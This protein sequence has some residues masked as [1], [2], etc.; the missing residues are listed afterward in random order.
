LEKIVG[1]YEMACYILG[2]DN[3]VRMTSRKA[4]VKKNAIH[5]SIPSS[6]SLLKTIERFL[7]AEN[8]ARVI[9][10]IARRLFHVDFF[11]QIP[12]Q[13]GGFNIHLMDLPSM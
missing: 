11:L 8:K 5:F 7:K 3:R 4:G 1:V 9:L 10:N 6:R 12:M 2:I 13:E